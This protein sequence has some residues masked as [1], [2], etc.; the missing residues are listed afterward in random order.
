MGPWGRTV[1]HLG[2]PK[3]WHSQMHLIRL[4]V[5]H[6]M[7]IHFK[8][9]VKL[10]KHTGVQHSKRLRKEPNPVIITWAAPQ[11]FSLSSSIAL[12][13][14]RLVPVWWADCAIAWSLTTLVAASALFLLLHWVMLRRPQCNA[15]SKKKEKVY[16]LRKRST[17]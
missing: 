9:C 17:C 6:H 2:C 4:Y 10:S 5:S 12:H 3:A 16:L 11:H 1:R 8:A 7:N 13:L 15:V 14:G